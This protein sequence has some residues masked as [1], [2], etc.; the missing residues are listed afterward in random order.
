MEVGRHSNSRKDSKTARPC[1]GELKGSFGGR[2]A[3]FAVLRC[4]HL[5]FAALSCACCLLG[6]VTLVVF[7]V[8]R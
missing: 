1:G 6:Q 7:N 8:F 5:C 4:L 2:V 3:G